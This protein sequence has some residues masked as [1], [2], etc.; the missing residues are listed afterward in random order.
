M[1]V[2]LGP[3]RAGLC[4]EQVLTGD[5]VRRGRWDKDWGLQASTPR[6]PLGVP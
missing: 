6:A 5:G 4:G 1:A 2:L 3:E